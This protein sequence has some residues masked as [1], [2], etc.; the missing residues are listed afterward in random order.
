M[1]FALNEEQQ[2]LK[3]AA[4]KW[5]SERYPLDRDFDAPQDDRWAE[6]AELGWLGVSISEDEGA[7]GLGFV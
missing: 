7:V 1:D 4:R 3:S 5:L 6:L 2:E